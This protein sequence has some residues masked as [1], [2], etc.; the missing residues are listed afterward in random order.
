MPLTRAS[1]TRGL[2]CHSAVVARLWLIGALL[3][4]ILSSGC[5][6]NSRRSMTHFLPSVSQTW[7]PGTREELVEPTVPD[8]PSV[9]ANIATAADPQEETRDENTLRP[10][11]LVNMQRK[12][13]VKG[14]G[15]VTAHGGGRV[16]LPPTENER[17]AARRELAAANST[18][19]A[20]TDDGDDQLER[21]K[22]ALNEDAHRTA[23]VNPAVT[24]S[25]EVRARVDSLLN[26]ARRLFDVGQLSDAKQTAQLAQELGE[27]ARLDF[28]PD[29]DR[30][31]DLVHQIDDQL[32]ASQ[33]AVAGDARQESMGN[34]IAASP[35]SRAAFK[36]SSTGAT[37]P[38]QT[39]AANEE[40][41]AT[42]GRSWLRGRGINVFRRDAKSSATDSEQIQDPLTP[43][44]SPRKGGATGEFA[45]RLSSPVTSNGAVEITAAP[46]RIAADFTPDIESDVQ[47]ETDSHVAVVQ[48]NRSMALARIG[49]TPQAMRDD[50]DASNVA[51]EPDE[52]GTH[53]DS[54][55]TLPT[56]DDARSS[57][58]SDDNW[59]ERTARGDSTDEA[60]ALRDSTTSDDGPRLLV[61]DAVTAPPTLEEVRPMSPFRNVARATKSARPARAEQH[62]PRVS[63]TG[64]AIA[65]A[66][67]IVC[68]LLAITFYRR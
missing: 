44:P 8:E 53:T 35:S 46:T 64:W 63:A 61:D 67:L 16:A 57:G 7:W 30:P 37:L 62:E 42:N 2:L 49:S 58:R 25:S 51:R 21:L 3:P 5:V 31:I 45:D 27:T 66:V 34:D 20:G 6:G 1:L 4:F 19:S 48:A 17:Q 14:D 56:H 26:R 38:A 29:E 41:E 59:T 47:A 54:S 60:F 43:S 10:N 12:P 52:F 23:T 55:S 32:Q 39:A 15:S 50:L 36:S 11:G 40:A 33:A 68:S 65:S 28:A 24:A 22:A 9:T 18:G 13:Q